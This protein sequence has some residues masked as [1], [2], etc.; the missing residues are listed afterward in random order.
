MRITKNLNIL[1]PV[2]KFEI[3]MIGP[4]KINKVVSPMAIQVVLPKSWKIDAIFHIKVLD[5][6]LKQS[7]A[8]PQ[9]LNK[10]LADMKGLVLPSFEINQIFDSN[11]DKGEK[12]VLYLVQWKDTLNKK[13]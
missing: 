9:D 6:F 8:P 1:Q 3:K 2:E 7:S 5:L 12:W 13:D 10:V 4:F 11:D